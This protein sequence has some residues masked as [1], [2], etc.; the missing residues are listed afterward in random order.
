MNEALR[1]L[2][3]AGFCRLPKFLGR[4]GGQFGREWTFVSCYMLFLNTSLVGLSFL[5]EWQLL[6]NVSWLVTVYIITNNLMEDDPTF[7]DDLSALSLAI[8]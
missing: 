3:V 6:W 7:A 1:I 5:K 4:R 2:E 8:Y